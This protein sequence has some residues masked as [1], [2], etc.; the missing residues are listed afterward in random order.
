MSTEPPSP[1]PSSS[2]S[3]QLNFAPLHRTVEL[4][5]IHEQVTQ[6]DLYQK[7]EQPI[8]TTRKVL[9]KHMTVIGDGN[10][11]DT[12]KISTQ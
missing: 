4:E 3:Q 12:R 7:Q 5:N 8:Q 1:L 10:D 11:I 6:N 9:T 2:S